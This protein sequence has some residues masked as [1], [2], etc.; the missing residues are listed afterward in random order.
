MARTEQESDNR[1]REM[2]DLLVLPRPDLHNQS[3]DRTKKE[4]R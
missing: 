2:A 4:R 1:R 3:W